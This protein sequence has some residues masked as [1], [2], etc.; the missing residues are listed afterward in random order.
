MYAKL[1]TSSLYDIFIFYLTK[2]DKAYSASLEV[3]SCFS[4]SLSPSRNSASS[5]DSFTGVGDAVIFFR[6]AKYKI[7]PTGTIRFMLT[8][9]ILGSA[10]IL[11]VWNISP[12][13]NLNPILSPKVSV[14]DMPRNIKIAQSTLCLN[15]L[16][17][18]STNIQIENAIDKSDT[19]SNTTL[20][21]GR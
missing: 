8:D 18:Q 21:M 17:K 6:I 7:A 3:C 4:A 5:S 12:S 14:K 2:S 16:R 10:T 20:T 1:T 19:T 13:I 11:F 15:F 9:K